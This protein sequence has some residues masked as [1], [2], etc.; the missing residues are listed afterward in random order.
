[1][2]NLKR[3]IAIIKK[4]YYIAKLRKGLLSLGIDISEMTDAELESIIIKTGK[5]VCQSGLY[6][7]Q[8]NAALK[9]LGNSQ[10][11]DKK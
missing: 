2:F 5:V 4:K 6:S 8:A 7:T 11:V 1:M 10:V 9:S 3:W